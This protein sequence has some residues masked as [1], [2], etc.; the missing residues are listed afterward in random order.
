MSSSAASAAAAAGITATTV[1]AAAVDVTA[2]T[3]GAVSVTTGMLS[4][5]QTIKNTGTNKTLD[6]VSLYT[7]IGSLF[8]GGLTTFMNK[9]VTVAAVRNPWKAF[10][11]PKKSPAAALVDDAAAAP[12][13]PAAT[14]AEANEKYVI[15]FRNRFGSQ[16]RSGPSRSAPASPGSQVS[17]HATIA[18]A[19]PPVTSSPDPV[20]ASTSARAVSAKSAAPALTDPASDTMLELKTFMKKANADENG[21]Q[22]KNISSALEE[23]RKEL[24]LNTQ[25][26]LT[27]P[28]QTS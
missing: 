7:G 26:S 9:G 15:V 3:L 12:V 27:S 6:Q 2:I 18:R 20:R 23:T 14:A 17:T 8:F 10:K 13:A 24:Q 22:V 21:G 5:S 11:D 19:T 4:L 28:R 16:N 1:A 25:R